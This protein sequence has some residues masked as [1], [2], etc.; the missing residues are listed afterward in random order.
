MRRR[1][2]DGSQQRANRDDEAAKRTDDLLKGLSEREWTVLTDVDP[3]HGLDHVVVGPGGV[4]AIASRF[5]EPGGA[6]VRDGVLW[7]R[8]G[9]D[10]R[11]ERP[12]VAINRHALDAARSLHREIR[13]RT[14]RGPEVHP[15]VVL[16]CEFPQRVAESSRIAFVHGRDLRS[17]LAARSPQLD[18]AGRR[19]IV[20]AVNAI[21]RGPHHRLRA[22]HLPSR[23][24][25]A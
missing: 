18:D 25:A 19:E 20:Q 15:V 1:K 3:K 24:R 22:P 12:G 23:R 5:P 6:R 7:L 13:T 11:A 4:F 2:T 17:W 10:N 8:R 21:P 14:G 9:G 16:W